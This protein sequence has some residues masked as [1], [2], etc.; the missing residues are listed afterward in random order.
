MALKKK[1]QGKTVP[2][3][4][5]IHPAKR[6]CFTLHFEEDYD[7]SYIEHLKT[8]SSGGIVGREICPTTGKKH[9]QGYVENEKKVRF[10]HF[11]LP[12][13]THWE[14][15]TKPKIANIRYCSKEGT[16]E[17]WGTCGELKFPL[18]D[19]QHPWQ[20]ELLTF[21][22]TEPDKRSILWLYENAGNVG[23]TSFCKHVVSCLDHLN[24]LITGGKAENMQNQIATMVRTKNKF[25]KV[26]IVD[27]PRSFD[28]KWLSYPGLESI[29]NMLFYSGKYEGHMVCGPCPHLLIFSNE[30]PELTQL[31][32][33]RWVIGEIKDLQIEWKCVQNPSDPVLV[34]D[35]SLPK[36]VPAQN[37]EVDQKEVCQ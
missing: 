37:N 34:P 6:W 9:F 20:E 22:E 14:N 11:G 29:K 28:R 13:T 18:P 23:K 32:L 25:P 31:S 16:S 8:C 24:P 17:I 19:P 15:A 4:K 7:N 26:V 33:D 30:P 21:L 36:F 2:E 12:E 35:K 1:V 3:K 10:Q 5:P 27:L